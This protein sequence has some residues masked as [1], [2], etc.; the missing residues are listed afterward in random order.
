LPHAEKDCRKLLESYPES[1][2]VF[3]ILGMVF[4]A[5]GKDLQAI[6]NYKKATE[7]KP[8]YADAFNNI[9]IIL[10]S[11]GRPEEAVARF[12]EAV[13][14][15]PDFADGCNNLG[16]MRVSMKKPWNTCLKRSNLNPLVRQRIST[17]Q[18]LCGRKES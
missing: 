1:P 5:Q 13:R 7:L 12:E 15:D 9:G 8:D 16:V 2:L 18:N 17:T 4:D 10:N 11:M 3:N 6:E 14:A